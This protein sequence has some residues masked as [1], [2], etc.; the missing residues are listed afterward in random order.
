MS[1]GTKVLLGAAGLVLVAGGVSV[2]MRPPS[3]QEWLR[4]MRGE[5]RALRDS[6]EAC[7][8]ALAED[9]AG[10]KA[11]EARVD[12]MR[13]RIAGLEDIVPDGVP[14]D[15]Y[16]AYLAAVDSFNAAVPDWRPTA[17]SL[18]ARRQACEAR[19]EAHRMLADS[20]RALADALGLLD[21]VP[22]AGSR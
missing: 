16:P 2:A 18:A 13:R 14:A 21:A 15:S 12:S 11:Y 4:E 7:S 9:Q 6:A 19:I 1:R 3:R 10:F 5:L 17:D 22:A 20:V 8:A